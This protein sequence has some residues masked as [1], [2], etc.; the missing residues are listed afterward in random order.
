MQER[1]RLY[2]LFVDRPV[3][4]LMLTF[5]LVAVGLLSLLRLPLAFVPEGLS[6]GRVMVFIPVGTA[7]APREVEQKIVRPLEEQLRT[8]PGIRRLRSESGSGRAFVSV[9]LDA[10][11]D[12]GLVAAEV[13]D[14]VQRA[15]LEWP[16]DVDRWFL[17]RETA[18]QMPLAWFQM[19]TP[20]RSAQWDAWMDQV[21]KPRL[22]SV[23]G[24]GRVDLWGILDQTVRI[25]FDRD[26]LR[27]HGV[28]LRALVDRLARENSADPC[29][30]FDNGEERLLL[31]VDS[32]FHSLE[33]LEDF[34]V[35]VGLK[36]V[37]VARI[38]RVPAVRDNLSRYQQ[39]YTYS[40]GVRATPG[41]NPVATSDRLRAAFAELK[42]DPRFAAFDVRF[43]FDQGTFIRESL[44][45]LVKSALE[46]ALLA[47]GVLWLFLRNLRATLLISLA[48][49]LSLLVAF[50]QLFFAG[51]SLNVLTMAGLTLSIGM[52]VD[53]SIV[54]LENIVRLRR[55]G[56]AAR[57]ACVQGTRQVGLAVT[58][59]TLTTIVVFLPVIFMTGSPA[60]RLMMQATG[61]PLSVTLGASLLVA[62][63][64]LPSGALRLGA[65]AQGG[66]AAA[67]GR[68]SPVG[69][70]R[71]WNHALLA[72]SLRHRL[73]VV[74]GALLLL[75]G[76]AAGNLL[77]PKLET[78]MDTDPGEGRSCTLHF[79]LPR[80]LSLLD[81]QNEIV[82]MEDFVLQRKQD[83][84]VRS[85]ASRFDRRAARIE[86][87]FELE[88]SRKEAERLGKEIRAVWPRRP[89]IKLALRSAEGGGGGGGGGG[90]EEQS[91]RNFVLRLWGRDSEHL[92]RLAQQVTDGLERLPEVEF[93][94]RGALNQR[95]EVVVDLD[96]DR[97]E[98]LGVRPDA[99]LGTMRTGLQGREL[100][101]FQEEGREVRLIA[102]FDAEET[103]SLLDLKETQVFSGRGAD[104]RIAEMSD[105]RIQ[106]SLASIRRVDGRTGITIVGRRSDGVGAR[107]FRA[108]LEREMKRYPLPRG[109]SWSEDSPARESEEQIAEL[110]QAMLLSVVLVFLLMG[111]L[112][113]S[114]I[115]PAACLVT[116]PIALLGSLWSL[117]LILGTIDPMAIVGLILLCGVVVNNGIVLTDCVE[118]LRR[119]GR[120]RREAIDLGTRQRLRPILMTAASTILG[121]L[122][123]AVF[124]DA[125][126]GEG[127]SYVGLAVVVCCGLA[128]C[129]LVTA[130][131]V[132]LAYTLLDDL[133]AFCK[134]TWRRAAGIQ[135]DNSANPQSL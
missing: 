6:E 91:P 115:L 76:L 112:F 118:R 26:R 81:V 107:A 31:R 119:E 38:E 102:Q 77:M 67:G 43:Q 135:A 94:D 13:R 125:T 25:W 96:R 90:D 113:E 54:V 39:K 88:V 131:V 86:V 45:V 129:T 134:S 52:V 72:F 104:P 84:R 30:E 28:D 128:I 105:V 92:N 101:R 79:E 5:T 80:G 130:F 61:V 42:A 11:L 114:L 127:F 74:G 47:F 100:S 71:A 27:A 108:A 82:A 3:L 10:D 50:A 37:D 18:S 20:E 51:G 97:V 48:L 14:R 33:E 121:M 111:V 24:V 16:P 65:T 35:R 63:F 68:W 93:I 66:V 4:T 8:I 40:G 55:E 17:W 29:G 85:V 62:L 23:D 109:Y 110:I 58:M 133:A 116:I 60:A 117:K 106:K 53:N 1:G 122:P 99:V 15:R 126:G 56:M 89:G 124:G 59:S 7:R 78:G 2:A 19:L 21:I 49:P 41:A 44:D 12:E 75:V 123:M 46:G 120:S 70:L 95:E 57:A 73:L 87:E 83:W 36:L 9:Q 64:L 132:P 103:P 34:P 22:E 32:R 98:E 69:W